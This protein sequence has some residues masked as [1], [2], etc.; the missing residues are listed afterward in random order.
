MSREIETLLAEREITRII[1]QYARGIDQLDF[2]LVRDCFHADARVAYGTV[3]EGSVDETISWLD[4]AL[5]RLQGTLHTFTPPWIDLDLDAGR[6][7][8]ETRSINSALFPADESGTAI[9]NVTGTY[10]YDR[11]ERRD[12]CW[13][14]VHRRNAGAWQ[15]NV[16]DLPS[17]PPPI[18]EGRDRI[19]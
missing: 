16:P 4:D 15:L 13:R 2:D 11:F 9:Q 8:C 7:E 17:P 1:L 12:D 18:D 6:A 5:R 10:Y 19:R 3:F 14:I